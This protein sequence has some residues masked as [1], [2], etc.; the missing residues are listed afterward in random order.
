M[1]ERTDA[2]KYAMTVFHENFNDFDIYIED[3]APGYQKIFAS[4][5]NRAMGDNVT[6]E[7]VFPL[8]SRNRVIE[9]ASRE[10]IGE[11]AKR[12]S[13]YLVDGDLYL[14]A[15]EIQNLPNNVVVLPRYCVENFLIEE[16]AL[17]LIMDDE[18]PAETIE[19]LR[20]QFDYHGWLTRAE[21]P[22]RELFIVFAIAH[23][24]RSG[25]QTVCRGYSSICADA[26]GEIDQ[27]KVRA[28]CTEITDQLTAQFGPDNVARAHVEIEN[29]INKSKCFVS[30]YVSAKDFSLPL[31]IARMRSVTRSKAPNV[32]LKMRFSRICNT[33]PLREV[34]DAINKIVN[35]P[36]Q[37]FN[38]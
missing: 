18:V 25:I 15:G 35:P 11:I 32:N 28:I 38:T 10:P 24:L 2:A 4:L 26:T 3:T 27:G 29:S 7:R 16:N 34:V 19:K 21:T 33:D 9:M 30:T 1:L 6:I 13:V 20:R 8:G 14:L 36:H 12:P 22:L 37:E 5:L 17:A 31:L 23:K